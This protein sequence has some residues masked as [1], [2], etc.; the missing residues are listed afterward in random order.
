M[1]AYNQNHSDELQRKIVHL[2]EALDLLTARE[3]QILSAALAGLNTDD[4]AQ[5][6]SISERTVES[7]RSNI[8]RKFA[9]AS[10]SELFR[11]A[12]THSFSRLDASLLSAYTQDGN[13]S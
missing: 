6:F 8:A 5:V 4:T 3:R 1:Y 11:I 13:A 2:L 10:L 9:V 12:A 7:H